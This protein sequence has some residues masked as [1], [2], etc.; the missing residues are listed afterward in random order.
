MSGSAHPGPTTGGSWVRPFSAIEEAKER[1]ARW[2][3]REPAATRPR[4]APRRPRRIAR[5]R[6]P[7]GPPGI[8]C[9]G[10]AASSPSPAWGASGAMAWITSWATTRPRARARASTSCGPGDG[11]PGPERGGGSRGRP[12]PPAAALGPEPR[13]P[14]P[15]PNVVAA[16]GPPGGGSRAPRVA[17]LPRRSP[18]SSRKPP[19]PARGRSS[20]PRRRGW[21][22]RLRARRSGR[23][24]PGR[25]RPEASEP[26]AGRPADPA[27]SLR[28]G[29]PLRA[30][31]ARPRP[32]EPRPREGSGPRDPTRTRPGR[33]PCRRRAGT[34]ASRA[35]TNGEVSAS[36]RLRT[37]TSGRACHGHRSCPV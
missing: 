34:N 18:R 6:W 8:A 37:E 12:T 9:P 33:G 1:R 20:A 30:R 25:G 14:G 28:R 13:G 36:E 23:T 24:T 35:V 15:A 7:S 2:L 19:R 32:R 11:D 26:R 10:R 16:S 27:P 17:R 5:R 22:R 21:G 4:G 29:R 3:V 31:R